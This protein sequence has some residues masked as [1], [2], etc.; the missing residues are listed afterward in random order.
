MLFRVS[1]VNANVLGL[2]EWNDSSGLSI[3]DG[4]LND[5]QGTIEEDKTHVILKRLTAR[6]GCQPFI[7]LESSIETVHDFHDFC[8]V[9]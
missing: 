1:F 8:K 5:N 3:S 2:W 6:K 9:L 4:S 7:Y